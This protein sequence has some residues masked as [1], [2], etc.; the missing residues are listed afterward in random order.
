MRLLGAIKITGVATVTA[1]AYGILHDQ[2]TIRICPEYFTVAHPTL[3]HIDSLTVLA[4][5]WGVIATWWVGVILGGVLSFAALA[6]RWPV[7]LPNEVLTRIGWLLGIVSIVTAIAGATA[8][9]VGAGPQ[10]RAYAPQVAAMI[11]PLLHVRFM[12]AWTMHVSSY[13]GGCIGGVLLAMSIL[14]KRRTQARLRLA[15]PSL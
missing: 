4:T 14:W 7:I 9:L 15:Q 2:V 3:I 10:L 5:F 12:V 11:D 1:V 6:G 8:A 13:V